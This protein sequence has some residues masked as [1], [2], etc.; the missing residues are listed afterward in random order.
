MGANIS[1]PMYQ[2]TVPQRYR[3]TA[4]KCRSCGGVNFPPQGACQHCLTL[5]DFDMTP[6]SG[7]GVV[8][9]FTVISAGGA[10][11]E[12]ARQAQMTGDYVVAI[13]RLEEGP[14]IVGQLVGTTEVTTGMPVVVTIRKIYE[15]EGVVRY[16]FKFRPATASATARTTA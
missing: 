15:Q 1:I 13:G 3:L 4:A 14:K 6:L 7:R 9:A 10:P 16:G 8:Y 12:F 5:S 11:P 2:R